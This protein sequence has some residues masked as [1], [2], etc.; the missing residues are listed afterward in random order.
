MCNKGFI[1]NP[2]NCECKCDRSCDVGEYLDYK[3]CKCKDKLI[4]KLVEECCENIDRNEM[5]YNETGNLSSSD[6]KCS[7]CSL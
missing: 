3:N 6:Y 5:I 7:S 4:D 2:S 1:L